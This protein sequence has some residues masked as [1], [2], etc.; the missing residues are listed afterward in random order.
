[1]GAQTIALTTPAT[2]SQIFHGTY[3]SAQKNGV[4][5]VDGRPLVVNGV[6]LDTT[7]E[8]VVGDYPVGQNITYQHGAVL[9]YRDQVLQMRNPDNG[10]SG[11][12]YQE[13]PGIIKF[14]TSASGD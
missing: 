12:D 6:L 3:I 13:L 14:N 11:G 9:V 2:A 10:A 5:L 8:F 4:R 7:D 1:T